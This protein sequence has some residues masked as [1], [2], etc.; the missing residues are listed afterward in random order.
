MPRPAEA[1]DQRC[2]QAVLVGGV[3]VPVGGDDR[4]QEVAERHVDGRQVLERA[5]AHGQDR[6]AAVA[7]SSETRRTRS[8]CIAPGRRAPRAGRR[9]AQQVGDRRL[10][11]GEEAVEDRR[12]ED[13]AAAVRL[14]ASG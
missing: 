8:G 5:D 1:L 7:A 11:R 9:D 10:V 2:P 13:R 12:D 3:Q 14:E 6:C 4:A